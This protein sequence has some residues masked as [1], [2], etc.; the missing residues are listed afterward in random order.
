[1][2]S[3]PELWIILPQDQMSSSVPTRIVGRTNMSNDV[4]AMG[5]PVPRNRRDRSCSASEGLRPREF[6]YFLME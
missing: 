2:N 1:M 6:T 4:V 5:R 3:G